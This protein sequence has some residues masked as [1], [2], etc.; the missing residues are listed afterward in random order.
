MIDAGAATVCSVGADASASLVVQNNCTQ[1][2]DLWWVS[3]Q[4]S[5]AFYST[6][7]AGAAVVQPS[8]AS[9]PWRLRLPDAGPVIKEIAPLHPGTTVVVV[10]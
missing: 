8:F 5:E 9:H 7:Q 3:Y 2:V 1:N 4:C 10:P 6:I